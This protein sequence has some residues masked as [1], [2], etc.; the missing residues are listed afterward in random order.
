MCIEDDKDI[1]YKVGIEDNEELY[2]ISKIGG[3][4]QYDMLYNEYVTT[5]DNKDWAKNLYK[6]LHKN[7]ISLLC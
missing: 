3:I 2:Y 1:I 6:K 7:F 5:K 4:A